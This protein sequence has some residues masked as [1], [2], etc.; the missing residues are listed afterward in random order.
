M[1]PS[2]VGVLRVSHLI[3]CCVGLGGNNVGTINFTFV[4]TTVELR[5]TAAVLRRPKLY[6][7]DQ[8]QFVGDFLQDLKASPQPYR[9]LC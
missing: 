9:R 4:S 8:A 3:A 5:V 7:F 2:F 1:A 6:V